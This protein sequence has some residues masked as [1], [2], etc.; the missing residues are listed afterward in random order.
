MADYKKV[1]LML[2][3]NLASFLELSKKF[4]I[5]WAIE[6]KK[7]L[8][9][10]QHIRKEDLFGLLHGTHEIKPKATVKASFSIEKEEWRK[11]YQKHYSLDLNFSDLFIPEKPADGKWRLIIIAEG[12][13][14]NQV[15]KCMS[16]LFKT[17]K[18]AD[19]LDGSVTQN[20]RKSDKSYAICVRDEIEPDKEFLGK[21]TKQADSDMKIGVT[22]LERMIHEIAYFEDTGKHL[23]ING[24]T[25]CSGSRGSD[26]YV[27]SMSWHPDSGQVGVG[28][29]RLDYSDSR[30]GVRRAVTL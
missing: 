22:L 9:L 16:G 26:G 25:F 17:W 8:H 18:Y 1:V 19:D 11:F 14:L 12:L 13:K 29:C 3:E 20:I 2:G 6:P 23:D 27:P 15:Y 4:L 10:L 30:D 21:S 5:D 7:L 28:W 24:V